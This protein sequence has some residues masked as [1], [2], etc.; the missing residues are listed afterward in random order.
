MIIIV[1][2]NLKKVIGCDGIV[3]YPFVLFSDKRFIDNQQVMNHERI[4][5]RQVLE[6]WVLPFY[7]MYVLEFLIRRCSSKSK[8]EAYRKISFEQEAYSNDHNLDYLKNRRFFG[9]TKYF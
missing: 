1:W 9:F 2:K 3:L 6:L 5:I 4:H 7:L 8:Y